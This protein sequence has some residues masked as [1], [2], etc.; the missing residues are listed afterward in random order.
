M[1]LEITKLNNCIFCAPKLSGQVRPDDVK[2]LFNG[3]KEIDASVYEDQKWFILKLPDV[4]IVSPNFFSILCQISSYVERHGLRLSIISNSKIC[5]LIVK[6][7]I[8]RMVYYAV[9]TEEFYKIHGIDTSKEKA[10]VFLNV[11]LESTIT[12]L[13]ILLELE[14]V[15][16]EVQILSD[17]K[18]IP[19]LQ[20][21]AVAAIVSAHFSGNLIIGFS[22]AVYKK[23]MTK[24]LQTEITEIDDD[25]RD[26]A[27]EFLNVIIGQTKTKLNESGYAIR[28][29]IPSVI[30]GDNIEIGPMGK[31]PFVLIKTSTDIGDIHLLL[32]TYPAHAAGPP[33]VI[34]G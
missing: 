8:E 14:S 33:A 27:G 25:I 16:N 26:G 24:F 32:S 9:S 23:A 15:K 10:R 4:Q 13:K 18:K 30:T 31:M 29:V 3:V 21:G 34:A 5:N 17:P 11:L 19:S 22:S 28:Q 12:T 6:N 20:I 1:S 7:G 2:D